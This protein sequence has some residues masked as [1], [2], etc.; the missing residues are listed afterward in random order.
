MALQ[1]SSISIS[2]YLPRISAIPDRLVGLVVK[3]S[4]SIAAD[5][6]F[7]SRFLRGDFFRVESYQ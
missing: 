5:Q 4:A 3:A 7:S 6:G 2:S 1:V